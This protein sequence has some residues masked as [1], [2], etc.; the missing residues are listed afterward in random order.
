LTVWLDVTAPS[1]PD[2]LALYLDELAWP[3]FCVDGCRESVCLDNDRSGRYYG[4]WYCRFIR[5][6][7]KAG[8]DKKLRERLS[9][10]GIRI[11]RFD[12]GA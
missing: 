9:A 10:P 8:T 6:N 11:L 7:G 2:N 12:D 5:M 4:Q 3:D 1:R